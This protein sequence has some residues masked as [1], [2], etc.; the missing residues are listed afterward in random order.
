ML[1]KIGPAQL[2]LEWQ[3]N[4]KTSLILDNQNYLK[5]NCHISFTKKLLHFIQRA[6]LANQKEGKLL[7]MFWNAKGTCTFENRKKINF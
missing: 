3:N 7:K 4:K 5:P 2:K 6:Y 1:F